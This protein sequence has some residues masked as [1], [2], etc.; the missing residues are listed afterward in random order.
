MRKILI[1]TRRDQSVTLVCEAGTQRN[2]GNE[3]VLPDRSS[4]IFLVWVNLPESITP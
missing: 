3:Q 2:G 4:A 1:P